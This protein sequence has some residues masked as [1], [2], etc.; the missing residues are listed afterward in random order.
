MKKR[1][2]IGSSVEELPLANIAKDLL[3]EWFDVIIWDDT[4]WEKSTVKLNQNILSGL[5]K[6]SLQFD[7]GIL[8]GTEDDK[9]VVRGE[10]KLQ[11]RDNILFELG[12]FMGRLGVE[13]CAFVIDKSIKVLTDFSGIK[14]ARFDKQ[15]PKS[16]KKAIL[17]VKELFGHSSNTE[18]NFFPS[19][20]L[21]A[22]YFENFIVPIC[23]TILK[24]K[25]FVSQGV[26]Y[27]ICHLKIIVPNNIDKDVNRQFE[28]L[29]K[30][31]STATEVF[32]YDGRPRNI[33]VD[34]K[35]K[36][37]SLEF[38]D[39]PTIVAGINYAIRHLLPL[40][41]EK[42]Q[43]EYAQILDRELNRFVATLEKLIEDDGYKGIAVIVWQKDLR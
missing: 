23:E 34:I 13:K 20:T 5:L 36:N 3:E 15:D 30:I 32:E 21:A 18:V 25:G 29:K 6:A 42:K 10:E 38:V 14:L 33:S 37:G 17:Q 43:A 41:F 27:E 22:V 1:L 2:F 4:I 39:F 16:F 9:V 26:H 11:P 19:A 7:F 28:T 12:L 40:E 24:N 8:L 31:I 35:S